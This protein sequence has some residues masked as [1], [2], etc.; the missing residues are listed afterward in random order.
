VEIRVGNVVH[1]VGKRLDAPALEWLEGVL[2]AMA[3]R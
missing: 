3:R 2:R 1:P